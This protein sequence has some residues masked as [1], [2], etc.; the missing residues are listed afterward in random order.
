MLAALKIELAFTKIIAIAD[1]KYVAFY[2]EKDFHLLFLL[3]EYANT[4]HKAKFNN[5]TILV[6]LLW[7]P[8]ILSGLD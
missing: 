2:L 8:L 6:M 5:F 4:M 3:V 7:I 1:R